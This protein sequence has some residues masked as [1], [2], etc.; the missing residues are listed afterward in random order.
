MARQYLSTVEALFS[1]HKFVIHIVKKKTMSF[2]KKQTF[3]KWKIS[4]LHLD[5][6]HTTHTYARRTGIMN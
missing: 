2:R 1:T 6:N 5:P 4:K 3:Y